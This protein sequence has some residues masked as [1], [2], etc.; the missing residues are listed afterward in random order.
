MAW[1]NRGSHVC[2]SGFEIDGRATPPPLWRI[3]FYNTG[4]NVAFRNGHVHHILTDETV[5]S[6]ASRSRMGGAGIEMDNW[7]GGRDSDFVNNVIHSIGPPQQRSSLVHGIYQIQPGEV[8]N[9][10]I[11]DVVGNGITL[12]HGAGSIRIMN[13]TIDDARG[14]GIYIG[15]GDSGP[16]SPGVLAGDDVTVERNIVV[17]SAWGIAEG[18]KTGLRNVYRDNLLFRNRGWAIRLQNRLTATGT[19]QADPLFEERGQRN[20][21][22]RPGS[23]AA[24]LGA[25]PVPAGSPPC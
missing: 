23:A 19:V 17:H 20:Y 1:W 5:F 15:S 3:G 22:L 24:G 14:G 16:V 25:S 10:V 9:N 7:Y 8:R 2:I 6:T 11:Y 4:S 12:W 18:G 21:M 13:N